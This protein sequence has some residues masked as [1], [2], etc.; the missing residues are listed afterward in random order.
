MPLLTNILESPVY[1]AVLRLR[2]S[3]SKSSDRYCE[4][5]LAQALEQFRQEPVSIAVLG[6]VKRGKSTLI[7]ALLGRADDAVAPIDRLPASSAISRFRWSETESAVVHFRD[8]RKESIPFARIREF[9]T[10]V[11]NSE[12]QRGV[13]S[14]EIRG[15]FARLEKELE[16]VDTPGAGSIHEHHDALVHAY[17]PHADAVIFL[18]SARMPIDQEELELLRALKTHDIQKVFFAMNRVDE[19][20]ETDLVDAEAHN[21]KML[22]AAGIAVSKLHRISAKGAFQGDWEKS[23][24]PSLLQEISDFLAK[25][26][27]QV[28]ESRL[29]QRVLRVAEPVVQRLEAEAALA[30]KSGA[31]LA[32]EKERLSLQ[33]GKLTRERQAAVGEFRL[34]WNRALLDFEQA[35]RQAEVKT[36]STLQ[37][38]ISQTALTQ[39]SKLAKQLPT[40][41]QAALDRALADPTRRLE[42]EM[43]AATEKLQAS[44]PSLGEFYAALS[45]SRTDSTATLTKGVVTTAAAVTAGGSLLAA[46]TT[47]TASIAA[48]NAAAAA[49][50]TTVL[51]PSAATG[52][53]SSVPYVGSLLASVTTGTATV[54]APAAFT[55]TPLWVALSGP[56]GWSL[57]G[58]GVLAVP[59]AWRISKLRT[60]DQLETAAKEQVAS[61]YSQLRENRV[62]HLKQMAE[63]LIEE[64]ELRLD[65]QLADLEETLE[66]LLQR[67]VDPAEAS[68]KSMLAEQVR[69]D[70]RQL[71]QVS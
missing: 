54:A 56:I 70:L 10:E 64:F 17:I 2:S 29:R 31:E 67:P 65:R 16:I 55:T 45:P 13:E 66:K 12:N 41:V 51:A 28:I 68:V 39:V 23:G 52:L 4:Q 15:P 42:A 57:I 1:S 24:V 36:Q 5:E 7:N 25:Q 40:M 8:G 46:G 27:R 6:R 43:H 47:A 9:A 61:V 30:N 11:G 60:K 59:F 71:Q 35:L 14:L 32:L 58:V 21:S 53:L 69:D 48:A 20:A 22:S 33:R 62:H 3:L 44:Y 49:A 18:V 34:K 38:E 37:N 50:T 63:S 26:K 19:G